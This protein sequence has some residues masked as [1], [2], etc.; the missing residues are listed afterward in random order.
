MLCKTQTPKCTCALGY[1]GMYCETNI[2]DCA[3][4]SES[5]VPCKNDGKCYDGVNSFTCDCQGTGY[6]GP[7]CSIDVDECMTQD[8]DCGHGNCKNLPGT[9]Q[10]VCEPGYCGYNC[11]MVNPCQEVSPLVFP[12]K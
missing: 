10:C 6:T 8:I 11:G 2:D 7:D 5:N 3:P 12:M 1:T 4:D 9:Y